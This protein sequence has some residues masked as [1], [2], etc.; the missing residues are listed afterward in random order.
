[1]SQDKAQDLFVRLLTHPYQG[2]LR[3]EFSVVKTE[4]VL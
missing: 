4:V 2:V 1:V 3:T